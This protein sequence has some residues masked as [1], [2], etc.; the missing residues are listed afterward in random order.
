MNLEKNSIVKLTDGK[1]YFVLET[2]TL[3]DI[4]YIYVIEKDNPLNLKFY[5]EQL[6]GN[7]IALELVEDKYELDLIMKQFYQKM[8]E[9]IQKN[10]GNN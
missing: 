9:N 2:L 1:L 5:K 8:K 6:V 3:N 10:N 7:Q 4:N